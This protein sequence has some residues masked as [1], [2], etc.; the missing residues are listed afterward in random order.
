[1]A[2]A[3]TKGPYDPMVI[4]ADIGNAT[5][6]V[7]THPA[8]SS[9]FFPSFVATV[10]VG[11]YEGLSKIATTRHHLSVDGANVLV[12]A[13]AFD[14]G[15]GADSLLAEYGQADA[16]KRYTDPRSLYCL[17]AGISAA[18]VE[19]DAIG[20]RLATGAPLSIF[21]THA[22]EIKRR[23]LGEHRYT[24]NGHARTVV[25]RDVQVYGEGREVLRLLPAEQRRGR[26]AVHDLGGRTWNV[27]LF[28]DGA[29]LGAKT[30]DMGIDKLLNAITSVSSDP[31]ARWALRQEMRRSGKAHSTARAELERLIGQA[32]DVIERKIPLGG[33]ERHALVGGGAFDLLPVLR[34]RYKAPAQVLNGDA[35]EG[36]N[37]AAYALA[38]S[39]VQ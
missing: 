27:L 35:P 19:A 23:F 31:G 18:F 26:I 38:A 28:K 33:A 6:S 20:V 36:A 15:L 16:W 8:R 1:M 11:A 25:V 29:L 2:T 17:L 34:A 32:L 22:E 3:A 37:A 30:Y 14:G 7:V 39:E 5:T 12:G 9:A 13:E 10:G 21:Q 4:G 24:Y